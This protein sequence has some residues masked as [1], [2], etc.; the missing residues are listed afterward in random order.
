MG[1][2]RLVKRCHLLC[3]LRHRG[4][5]SCARARAG[6]GGLYTHARCGRGYHRAPVHAHTLLPTGHRRLPARGRR[7]QRCPGEPRAHPLPYCRIGADHR[8]HAD[9]RR[10]LV[11]RGRRHSLGHPAGRTPQGAPDRPVYLASHRGEPAGIARIVQSVR[12]ADLLLR[13]VDARDDRHWRGQGR[14]R[15]GR[16]RRAG[17]PALSNNR[18]SNP[19]LVPARLLIRMLRTDRRGSHQQQRAELLR[20]LAPQRKGD[21]RRARPDSPVHFRG[22]VR[23]SRCSTTPRLPTT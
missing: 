5:S 19:L 20:P 9:H 1:S 6:H 21:P 18:R 8:L 15:P 13:G 17:S 11:L 12:P 10:K 22:L 3:R 14:A 16:A 23:P 7:L 2:A 4:N